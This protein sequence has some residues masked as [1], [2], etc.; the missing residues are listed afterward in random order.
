MNYG[1]EGNEIQKQILFCLQNKRRNTKIGK[2]EVKK[3]LQFKT[4]WE[5]GR[6]NEGGIPSTVTLGNL[7]SGKNFWTI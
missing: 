7:E 5:L 6:G 4:I 2:K 1:K 3:K